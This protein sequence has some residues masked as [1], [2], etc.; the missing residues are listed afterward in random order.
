MAH[1]G[2]R[3]NCFSKI[4]LVRKKIDGP[5]LEKSSSEIYHSRR[6]HARKE[7]SCG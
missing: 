1:E 7:M 4:K 5:R 3:N 6:V 2:E